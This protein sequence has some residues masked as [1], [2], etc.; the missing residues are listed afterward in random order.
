MGT[1]RPGATAFAQ[2]LIRGSGPPLVLC[3]GFGLGPHT[4][5]RTAEA[6]ADRWTVYVPSIFRLGRRWEA[7]AVLDALDALAGDARLQD[8]TLVGHSFGGGT[9]LGWAARRPE[10]VRRLVLVDSLA[11]TPTWGLARN[12]FWGSR[13]WRMVSLR[14]ALDFLRVP[15]LDLARAGWWGFR[16]HRS[17]AVAAVVDSG[18]DTAV[19]WAGR[20]TLLAQRDGA[21][22]ARALHARHVVVDPPDDDLGHVWVFRRPELF[23]RVMGELA[24]EAEAARTDAR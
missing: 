20:D 4:Y 2:V 21:E 1:S 23:R 24:G 7:D 18:V 6:L 5:K 14:A 9:A 22:L 12:F 13:F 16:A 11:L 17:E 15:P 10:L 8:L 3:P 19:V